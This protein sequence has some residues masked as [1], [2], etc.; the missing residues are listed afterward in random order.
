MGERKVAQWETRTQQPPFLMEE[1]LEEVVQKCREATKKLNVEA[2]MKAAVVRGAELPN[3]YENP[4]IPYSSRL[5]WLEN[6]IMEAEYLASQP[7]TKVVQAALADFNQF[8][9][10]NNHAKMTFGKTKNP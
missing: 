5:Q 4:P 3:M 8:A 10:E 6:C 2:G 1:D 7:D 9:E